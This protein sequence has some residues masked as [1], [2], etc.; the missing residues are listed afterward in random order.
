MIDGGFTGTGSA[1]FAGGTCRGWGAGG[2]GCLGAGPVFLICGQHGGSGRRRH[3]LIG[4]AAAGHQRGGK[5]K[6][7]G[8]NTILFHFV[9]SKSFW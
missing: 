4:A 1:A 8:E 6:H 7:Q 9:T 5:D 2:G 3:V